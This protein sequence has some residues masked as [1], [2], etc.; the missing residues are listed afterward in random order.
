MIV[1]PSALM[2]RPFGRID[3][4]SLSDVIFLQ[5]VFGGEISHWC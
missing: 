1:S 4:S 2:E 3:T 5:S